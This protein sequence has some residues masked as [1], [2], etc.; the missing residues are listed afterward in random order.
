[1]LLKTIFTRVTDLIFLTYEL[2]LSNRKTIIPT[3]IGLIIALTVIAQSNVLVESYRE[4][5]FAQVVFNENSYDKYRGHIQL[6][7]W[8]GGS[9]EDLDITNYTSLNQIIE[10]SS[11]AT[12]YSEYL[13]Q[14]FWT[15]SVRIGIWKPDKFN[16]NGV[17]LNHI[18]TYASSENNFYEEL[19]NTLKKNLNGRIP[20]NASEILLIRPKHQV[21]SW[22]NDEYYQNLS[23]NSLV[24]VTTPGY[25]QDLPKIN[26]TLRV[27]GIL[28]FYPDT[29]YY[30]ESNK[31]IS[32]PSEENSTALLKTYLGSIWDFSFITTPQYLDQIVENL[33]E[34][35]TENLESNLDSTLIGKI[36]LNAN[37]FNAYNYK[38]EYKKLQK[39]MQA[40]E[41]GFQTKGF[42]PSIYS[43]ILDSIRNFEASIFALILILVLV[44][45]PILVIALYL[46][47][48]SFGLIRRQKQE[49]IGI[50]KTRGG[51]WSQVL[52]ILIAEMIVSTIVAVI[53]GFTISFFFADLVMRSTEY[54]QFLGSPIKV[55]ITKEIF[56]TLLNLGLFF[57]LLLNFK[58]IIQMS[59]QE[60]IETLEP[61]EKQDPLW[62]RFYLD[63]IIFVIGTSVWIIVMSITRGLV[64]GDIEYN[65]IIALIL[66]V[67][68]LLFLPAPF[69]MFFGTIMVI[70]RFFPI[71]MKKLANLAWR[72]E[73]GVN[74]FAIRN[75]VRHKQAANR[76]VLL[77]T[78]ALSFSILSSSLIFSM[79]ESER[80][81]KYYSQGA[82]IAIPQET[83]LNETI[84]NMLEV[85]VSYLSDISGIYTARGDQSGFIDRRY[86]FLFID[87][88]TYAETAYMNPIF[89]LSSSLSSLMSRISDNNSVILCDKN[90]KEHTPQTKIGGEVSLY[91]RNETDSEL[92]TF[93]VAGTFKYWPRLYPQSYRDFSTNYWLVG[94]IGLFEKLNHS[95]YI[96]NIRAFFI[97]KLKSQ[98]NVE[99]CVEKIYNVTDIV[100]AAPALEYKNYRE[101]F[102]RKFSLSILN[103]DLIICMTISIVGIIMFAFFTYVERGKEIGVERALGMTRLQTG[104]S[105]LV[106]A[107]MILGFGALI[108]TTVGIYFVAMF[109]QA[110]QFGESVPPPIITYPV[111]L[112]IQILLGILTIAGIGTL[113]PAYMA[114]RKDISRILKVE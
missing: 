112:L 48:Y 32:Q 65:P 11:K 20:K 114:S 28:D 99:E 9:G 92:L 113:I 60:I 1:M 102:T 49:Q 4:E 36:Y 58:R 104:Q 5:I 83:H 39:F 27:V 108:G 25:Q 6:S 73:G 43:R 56:Q 64:I 26:K 77:I 105:F 55:V 98:N 70:S 47:V 57:A 7:F 10:E 61:T 106:E 94:S 109:L 87:P 2:I 53:I 42:Y 111:P 81:K 110:T 14:Y 89:K 79:D 19:N 22:Y 93:N 78:L 91:F 80:L 62:K 15:S 52:F 18:E 31:R 107:I 72:V 44:S 17:Y 82:D 95:S 84:K 69:F 74:A 38:E 3:M 100:P 66:M 90:L 59:R 51:S 21:E 8:G 96:N 75:I 76:A 67:L 85:N 33:T 29:H 50:I 63:V 46:V 35:L 103:S 16:D 37:R 24:N 41:Q 12:S 88:E 13:Q 54:L 97:A 30:S 101:S 71:L 86:Y 68:Q 34:N 40:L 23:L 45:L